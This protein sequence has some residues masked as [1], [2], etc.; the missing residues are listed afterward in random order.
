MCLPYPLIIYRN[1]LPFQS[2]TTEDA[3]KLRKHIHM[4]VCCS[5]IKSG[6]R[7]VTILKTS[8]GI[9]SSQELQH[10]GSFLLLAALGITYCS[11]VYPCI[12][13]EEVLNSFEKSYRFANKIK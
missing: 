7:E 11:G 12:E 9:K 2:C 3:I 6:H 5:N 10:T 13:N 8:I 4:K 1:S